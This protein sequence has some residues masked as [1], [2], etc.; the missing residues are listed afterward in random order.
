M[1]VDHSFGCRLE[2][3][4]RFIL[5]PPRPEHRLS[6]GVSL[7]CLPGWGL[8]SRQGIACC[9]PSA[10]NFGSPGKNIVCKL[11]GAGCWLLAAGRLCQIFLPVE[12]ELQ[13]GGVQQAI[14]CQE[15][16]PQNW[17]SKTSETPENVQDKRTGETGEGE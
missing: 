9:V 15:D 5:L 14:A 6:P 2:P 1:A 12:P 7:V 4:C 8:T 17:F 3:F 10:G 16:R 11:L 13:A